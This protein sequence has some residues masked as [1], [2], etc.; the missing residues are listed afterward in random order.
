VNEICVKRLGYSRKELV[1]MRLQRLDTGNIGSRD[2]IKATKNLVS[3]GVAVIERVFRARDG[4]KIP[5]EISI[6]TMKLR[7]ET[8]GF[9]VIKDITE[10]K[11][12]LGKLEMDAK[13][14]D[15]AIDSVFVHDLKGNFI[16][17]NRAAH[18]RLG[19]TKDE[20]MEKNLSDVDTP[21][22]AGKI[23][24]RVSQ[25]VEKGSLIF[26]TEHR[27]KNGEIMPLEVHA[28]ITEIS[29]EKYVISAGRDITERRKAE[30]EIRKLYFAVEQSSGIVVITD[31]K[32]VIVYVNKKF[33]EVTGYGKEEALGKKVS[34]L[35]SGETPEAV[36]KELWGA[37]TE[38][39]EWKGRIYNR[40]KNGTFYWEE[41]SISPMKGDRGETAGYIAI[42][43]D[44][45]E[46]KIMEERLESSYRKLKEL[47]VLKGNFLS[48]VSHELRTPLT[49]IKGFLA[50]LQRGVAGPVTEQQ[51]EYLGIIKENSDR[52]LN[53][54]S[55]LLDISKMESG[56][57]AVAKGKYDI[58]LIAEK[59]VA[60]LSPAA[61]IRGIKL[62]TDAGNTPLF[63]SFDEYRINQVMAN[64]LNN[65][66]KF[67]NDNST[68]IIKIRKAR[69]K[70]IT[71][72][73]YTG[74]KIA[75]HRMW[76]EAAVCDSGKGIEREHLINI[77]D[78][79]YQVNGINTPVF[80]GIG[81]GLNIVKNIIEAHGGAVWAESTG[82]NKGSVFK[83]VLPE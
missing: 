30:E 27:K 37:I 43:E 7:G 74:F 77:F 24:A 69:G 36:Y 2:I 59:T 32:G 71:I 21:E 18:E 70:D 39:R 48:M 52:L 38:G 61:G 47:D 80:K 11:A 46:K 42:K 82:R 62:K 34:M 79:F 76:I 54:I 14:L 40:K 26:E 60:A 72:P 49:S 81:M 12:V 29:G 33:T 51:A 75:E 67:S 15:A 44:V 73:D 56:T 65:A 35:K 50:F 57:F 5:V 68:I 1:G 22:F 83:F 63:A 3:D 55:D 20:L 25:L 45:T 4:T 78:R 16:Y 41:V 28:R 23:A 13:I 53:L 6:N 17:V 8:V 9:A 58:K 66:L 19:Y 31:T 64:L 10:R